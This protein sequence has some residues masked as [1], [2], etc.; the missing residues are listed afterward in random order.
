MTTI[1]HTLVAAGVILSAAFLLPTFATAQHG[2]PPRGGGRDGGR[3]GMRDD[4]RG[5]P[6]VDEQVSHMTADLA[7]TPAQVT[8]VRALVTA[9]H[10][11]A[12]S[13]HAKARASHD[14]ERKQMDAMH[15]G[16][17]K[18]LEGILTPEQRAKHQASMQSRRGRMG[19]G[20]PRRPGHDDARHHDSR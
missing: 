1:R 19:P 17:E 2:P 9:Q 16:M 11:M 15:D 12:D 7:L 20:G 4:R 18:S 14:A 5:P 6:T 8:R 3:G 13:M 10:A